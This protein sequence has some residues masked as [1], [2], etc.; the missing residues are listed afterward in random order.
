[1]TKNVLTYIHTKYHV[2][3]DFSTG[4]PLMMKYKESALKSVEEILLERSVKS[5]C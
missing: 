4:I 5:L 2:V 3:N 1:M